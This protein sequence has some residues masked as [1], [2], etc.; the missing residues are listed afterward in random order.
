MS[1]RNGET[2]N[3]VGRREEEVWRRRRRSK[4]GVIQSNLPVR[5]RQRNNREFF[6]KTAPFAPS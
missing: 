6:S 3:I 4:K 5:L 2:E 1:V